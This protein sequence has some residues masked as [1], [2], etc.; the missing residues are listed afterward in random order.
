MPPLAQARAAGAADAVVERTPDGTIL[1]R[2]PQPL[3][4]YPRAVGEW[5]TRWAA[6][7]PQRAFLAERVGDEWRRLNYAQALDAAR[8]I[9]QSLL[10]RGLGASARSRSCRTTASTT[11]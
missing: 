1:L 5:L 3:A 9:G 2:S 8:R 6:E 11:P 7:A 10:E 4:A